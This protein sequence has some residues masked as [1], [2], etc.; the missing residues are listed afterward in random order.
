MAQAIR[1]GS[2]EIAAIT[3][4]NGDSKELER[5][6]ELAKGK[7]AIEL[8]NAIGAIVN[9]CQGSEP[10]FHVVLRDLVEKSSD[11]V[12][13]LKRCVEEGS[14]RAASM[15]VNEG[16]PLTKGSL[17]FVPN[18]LK[19]DFFAICQN[20]ASEQ[21]VGGMKQI[22]IR[23]AQKITDE[24]GHTA[25]HIA[26]ANPAADIKIFAD[27]GFDFNRG[28][29]AGVTPFMLLCQNNPRAAVEVL[30]NKNVKIDLARADVEGRPASDYCGEGKLKEFLKQRE[31]ALEKDV[32]KVYVRQESVGAGVVAMPAAS[33]STALKAVSIG[34][35]AASQV[36]V[37]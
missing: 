14:S 36:Q 22:G 2:L 16:F 20:G 31:A 33:P 25:C 12:Q 8:D 24:K 34:Q 28:D 18:I 3:A 13:V 29:N 11:G 30:K 26:A 6:E 1:I 9:S 37:G 15:L 19:T 4:V 32:A 23:L 27:Y 10:K 5:F 17:D 35:V 7:S 21:I